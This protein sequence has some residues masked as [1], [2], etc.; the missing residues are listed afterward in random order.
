MQVNEDSSTVPDVSSLTADKFIEEYG[1][2][3]VF[4]QGFCKFQN[5]TIT[6]YFFELNITEQE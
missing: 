6:N 3:Y 5:S 4:M 2:T 1:D